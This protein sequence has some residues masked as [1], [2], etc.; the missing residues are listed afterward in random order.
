MDYEKPTVRPEI[1]KFFGF[2]HVTFWVGNAKQAASYYTTRLGFDFI[3]YQGLETGHREFCTHVVGNGAVRFAFTSPLNPGGHEE[4]DKHHALHGDGVKDVAFTVD[5]AAGIYQKAVSR[6]ATGVREPSTQKDDDGEVIT[7][8]VRTYGDTTHT[9]VQRVNFK[10]LFLPGFKAHPQ[11]EAINELLAPP[12]LNFIDHCVGNQ[13]DGEM[14]AAASWYEKM[15]DFHRFWS[16]D[17]KMLHTEYS[18]L[19]SVVVADFDELVK[20]PI[21]EPADG[22]KKSQIQEYVEF[23]GGPGVQ[24]IA[25]NC[26]D[27]I[28]VISTL[29]KRGC[30]FLNIPKKYYDNLRAKLAVGGPK[31]T[32]DLDRIEELNILIDYDDKGYIL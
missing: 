7:A 31:V 15:L 21:N 25:L 28:D 14:E 30:I 4:F 2:D 22:K 3:A 13:P 12:K 24:H 18:A 27:I 17:D 9:F 10:G 23:Y 1:G 16:I 29:K 6:G 5:D 20:M 11:K 19:R 32:E 8:T 26:S